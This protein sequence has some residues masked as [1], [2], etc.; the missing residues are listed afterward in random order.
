MGGGMMVMRR[1]AGVT[2]I[3]DPTSLETLTGEVARFLLLWQEPKSVK[4]VV[5]SHAGI[6]YSGKVAP[7]QYTSTFG[8]RRELGE[9]AATLV[10]YITS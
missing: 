7:G 1:P 3:F 8:V 5:S 2:G 10:R 4:A 9:T 6:G